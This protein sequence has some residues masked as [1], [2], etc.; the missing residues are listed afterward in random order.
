MFGAFSIRCAHLLESLHRSG[1]NVTANATPLCGT[2]RRW[3]WWGGT[4][5]RYKS[6]DDSSCLVLLCIS[7]RSSFCNR[8]FVAPPS[9]SYAR[10]CS[11]L[12]RR[13]H[14]EG[15]CAA[16]QN[17]QTFSGR[18]MAPERVMVLLYVCLAAD[19]TG[20]HE[21]SRKKNDSFQD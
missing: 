8:F 7:S 5:D 11:C 18:E 21:S 16:L 6:K 3:K 12:V 15:G 1:Q 19:G 4:E 17:G 2:S 9:T 14:G 13:L 10:T 20:F